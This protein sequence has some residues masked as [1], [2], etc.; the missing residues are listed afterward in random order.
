MIEFE[1][2]QLLRV[3]MGEQ[4]KYHHRPLYEAVIAEAKER[5]IA[6]ATVF[7]GILSYGMSGTL[8]TTK[9]FEFSQSL[10]IVIE[11]MD[12]QEQIEKFLPVVEDLAAESGAHVYVTLEEIRSTVILPGK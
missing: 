7:K 8:R 3:Y 4:A 10:P 2:R 5:G 6:G 12:T 9:I 1:N 11:I